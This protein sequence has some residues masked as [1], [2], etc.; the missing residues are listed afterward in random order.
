ML[1]ADATARTAA[2]TAFLHLRDCCART[3]SLIADTHGQQHIVVFAN[4]ALLHATA[5]REEDLVGQPAG[6]VLVRLRSP[7]AGERLDQVYRMGA[8]SSARAHRI[9]QLCRSTLGRRT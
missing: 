6:D 9:D 7:R 5:R 2:Q 3:R 4:P 8:P 1:P